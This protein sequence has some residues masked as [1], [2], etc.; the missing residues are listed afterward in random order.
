MTIILFL[1]SL[2]V[3]CGLIVSKIFE[4]KFQKTHFLTNVFIEGDKQIH[5]ILDEALFKYNRSRKIIDIFIFEFLPSYLYEILF[6]VKNHVS[7]KYHK[8]KE[9]F[10]GRKILKNDGAVSFF[11][12]R[13]AEEKTKIE[14]KL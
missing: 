6:K 9:D 13:L 14:K 1:I 3:I 12:K 7:D 2:F 5:H 4:I 10:R 11:L 8:A